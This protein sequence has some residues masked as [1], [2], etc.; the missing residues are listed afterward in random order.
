MI[1]TIMIIC[2]AVGKYIL[3]TKGKIFRVSIVGRETCLMLVLVH[4]EAM[5]TGAVCLFPKF[6][7]KTSDKFTWKKRRSNDDL[8]RLLLLIYLYVII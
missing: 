5:L 2:A 1:Y 8:V 7:P 3:I 4:R 6:I